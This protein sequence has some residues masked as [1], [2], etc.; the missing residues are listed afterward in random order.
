VEDRA[1]ENGG[2]I[3]LSPQSA[4]M[5]DAAGEAPFAFGQP[6]EIVTA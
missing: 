3:G 6:V 2:L 4:A 5:N 1:G